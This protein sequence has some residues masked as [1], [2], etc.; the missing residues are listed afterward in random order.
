MIEINNISKQYRRGTAV[1]TALKNITIKID[2][3]EFCS[4]IGSSGAGKSTLLHII[5]GLIHPDSGTLFYNGD[6]L[7]K[8]S[9][10]NIDKYR[11]ECLGFMFQ[12][13][14]L[15]PY[16]TVNENIKLACYNRKQIDNIDYFLE[17]CSLSE[18]KNKYPSE[19]SV[20]EKQR[21]AF[22]RAIISGPELLLADEPTGNLDP[23]NSKI[24]M[25]LLKEFNNKNGTVVLVSHDTGMSDYA[26]RR[27][28][29]E[30]GMIIPS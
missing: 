29:L 10:R 16:L 20:G 1:F 30:K 24:L 15:M 19:L 14:H 28:I 25:S 2:E 22:I 17:K 6:D 26:N 3:G 13:F 4:V 5:G 9:S 8:Q 12:Q 18:M 7:Y 23:V 11:K 27:I 21:T